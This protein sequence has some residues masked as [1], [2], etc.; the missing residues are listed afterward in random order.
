MA[1]T[2]RFGLLVATLLVL[3]GVVQPAGAS[4]PHA[5][6]VNAPVSAGHAWQ[7]TP[8]T[9]QNEPLRL[10]AARPAT[11]DASWIVCEP[12]T[13]GSPPLRRSRAAAVGDS[14]R[15]CAAPP[16]RSSRGPPANVS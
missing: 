2:G 10:V 9:S 7:G 4:P 12:A 15:G 13:V 1:R 16:P 14:R 11:P 6:V 3:V 8:H 5:P